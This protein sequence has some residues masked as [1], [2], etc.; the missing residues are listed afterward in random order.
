MLTNSAMQTM[1]TSPTSHHK[2]TQFSNNSKHVEPQDVKSMSANNTVLLLHN[3]ANSTVK[4][5]YSTIPVHT[6]VS[7]AMLH[8]I[9]AEP[10]RTC[11]RWQVSR[12]GC[13]EVDNHWDVDTCIFRRKEF[14][15]E[16]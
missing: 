12:L 5:P 13:R 7:T 4:L 16:S 15:A 1:V 9:L 3:Y 2:S 11:F 10:H 6:L 14:M 8:C